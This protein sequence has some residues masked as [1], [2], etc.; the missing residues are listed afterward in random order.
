[1]AR[2][3]PYTLR[4]ILVCSLCVSSVIFPDIN[5][6][7]ALVEKYVELIVTSH[8]ENCLWRKRGCDG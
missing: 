7:D 3:N 8:E 5:I 4:K 1:M 6:E 2:R